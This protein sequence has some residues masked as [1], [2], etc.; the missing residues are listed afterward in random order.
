MNDVFKQEVEKYT[1]LI[2]K[3]KHLSITGISKVGIRRVFDLIINELSEKFEILILEEDFDFNNVK[4]L[5]NVSKR[6]LLLIVYD[7]S[8]TTAEFR[9]A[10]Q[11]ILL[12][13]R[14]NLH[15]LISINISIYLSLDKAFN[16]TTKPITNIEI[17]KPRKLSDMNH[18]M[19]EF[20]DSNI[21][22][23]MYGNIF[24]LAGGIP[25]LMKRCINIYN[26]KNRLTIEDLLNDN[27]TKLNL[28]KIT[29][30]MHMLTS[31]QK[32]NFGLTDKDNIISRLLSRYLQIDPNITKNV[33]EELMYLFM[34]NENRFVSTEDI[35]SLINEKA[36]FSLWNRYK[37]IERVRK[38]LPSKYKL[39]SIRG[40]G[41][42]LSKLKT[43]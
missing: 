34:K 12:G 4:A 30:E 41:Y 11:K 14:S 3:N 38:K 9:D 36:T 26:S 6:P 23:K 35:D 39:E 17:L 25:G 33:T 37:Q 18:F 16:L 10:F 27:A 5:K 1:D 31:E 7:F 21:P 29:Q 24:K 32:N 19:K 13:Q 15:T 40:K 20:E 2:I 43:S 28:Q 22:K 8:S 42:Q